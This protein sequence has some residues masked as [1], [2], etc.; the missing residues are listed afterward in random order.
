MLTTEGKQQAEHKKPT[1]KLTSK[2]LTGEWSPGLQKLGHASVRYVSE[3]DLGVCSDGNW[4]IEADGPR[5]ATGKSNR[6]PAAQALIGKIFLLLIIRIDIT[7]SFLQMM[8]GNYGRCRD[9]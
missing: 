7:V 4:E 6:R 3:S 8:K 5:K 1:I 9:L 2:R